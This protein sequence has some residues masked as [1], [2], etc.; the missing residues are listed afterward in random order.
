M[1]DA[2][3]W[4]AT[5]GGL[6][7]ITIYEMDDEDADALEETAAHLSDLVDAG[8]IELITPAE[9]ADGFV[10]RERE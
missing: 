6:T 4:T 9:I 8:E 1:I 3:D 5:H 10:Y 2:I 7:T